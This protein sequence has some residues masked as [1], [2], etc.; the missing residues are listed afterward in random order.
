ML[1]K[2]KQDNDNARVAA[3]ENARQ[4]RPDT[5][6]RR[7]PDT[8]PQRVPEFTRLQ[9]TSNVIRGYHQTS[10]DVG[11]EILRNGFR[12]GTGGIAGAGIYFALAP[13]D[14]VGKAHHTGY[15]LQADVDV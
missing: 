9:K 15:M 4:A 8:P 1:W 6:P 7:R 11:P 13:E 12:P 2:K 14:T 3:E 5:P 10:P